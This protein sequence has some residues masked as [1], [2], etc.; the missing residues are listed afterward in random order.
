MLNKNEQSVS[1]E[2]VENAKEDS[3][4]FGE[5][6]DLVFPKVFQFVVWRVRRKEDAEDLVADVF[7]KILKNIGRFEWKGESYFW[8]WTFRITRNTIINFA[9][10]KSN[11]GP[12]NIDDLPEIRAP[13]V[14]EEEKIQDKVDVEKL[15]ELID[16]MPK[17]QA[18]I[19]T[20]HYFSELRNKEIAQSL[21]I[22]EKSVAGTLTRA[23][24]KLYDNYLEVS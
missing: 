13:E 20:M 8:A 22:G 23:R 1:R 21:G 6:Y 16:K 17:R 4:A 14:S 3:E 19:L 11:K 7:M 24:R 2:M 12:V 10:K 15:R 18:E 9:T 5:L